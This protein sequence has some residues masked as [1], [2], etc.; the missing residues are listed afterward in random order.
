MG[1]PP[2][3]NLIRG[4]D[5]STTA[6]DCILTFHHGASLDFTWAPFVT[7]PLAG[8]TIINLHIFK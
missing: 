1:Y 4:F 6:R 3:S 5:P 2:D 8:Q 7:L